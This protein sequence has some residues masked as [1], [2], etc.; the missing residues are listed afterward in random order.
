MAFVSLASIDLPFSPVPPAFIFL[1]YS[2][3]RPADRP[4]VIIIRDALDEAVAASRLRISLPRNGERTVRPREA[5]PAARKRI[6]VAGAVGEKGEKPRPESDSFIFSCV[7][8]RTGAKRGMIC[9]RG[10]FFGGA[11][12]RR[13]VRPILTTGGRMRAGEECS[14][15]P[16]TT[17]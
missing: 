2:S 3:R 4:F 12:R 17:H 13:A 6:V 11:V 15:R 9:R 1:I 16:S 5:I 7:A 8:E 10:P 14:L